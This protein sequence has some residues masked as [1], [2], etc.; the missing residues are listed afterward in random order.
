MGQPTAN[1]SAPSDRTRVR[2]LAD[3]GRYDTPTIHAILDEG[4]VC[5]LGLIVNQSPVVIPTNYARIGD[6]LYLHGAPGNATLRAL[7]GGV[8]ACVTVTLVDG[9]VLARSTLHHSLNYRSVMIF[10]TATEVSDF[11]EK[12][13]IL[14]AI[15]EHIVPG[16]GADIPGPTD[17]ELRATRLIR[18]PIDEASAKVRSGGPNDDPPDNDP[19]DAPLNCWTGQVPLRVVTGTPIPE[20]GCAASPPAYLTT[21]AR[22]ATSARA[23]RAADK[24]SSNSSGPCANPGKQT[25]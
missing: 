21:Y 18:L 13:R 7:A 22:S 25:S 3:R 8:P 19:T 23:S 1:Q 6:T 20:P 9:L 12:R 16:R 14:A 5:H 4:F 2:R 10:G 17:S 15:I 11:A 24:V